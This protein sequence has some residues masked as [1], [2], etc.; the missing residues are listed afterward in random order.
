MTDVQNTQE[1]SGDTSGEN[2]NDMKLEQNENIQNQ[3]TNNTVN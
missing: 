1:I 2:S 3:E